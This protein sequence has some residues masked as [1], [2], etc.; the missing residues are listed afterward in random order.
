L[1]EVQ[2]A[3]ACLVALASVIVEAFEQ[4]RKLVEVF[5]T[6]NVGLFDLCL[7]A[8]FCCFVLVPRFAA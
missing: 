3:I 2:F 5:E 1:I 4:R 6:G 8:A 7:G